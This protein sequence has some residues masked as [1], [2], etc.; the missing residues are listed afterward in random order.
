[1][2]RDVTTMEIRYGHWNDA[3]EAATEINRLCA[4]RGLRPARLL[5]SSFGP[6]NRMVAE[7]E[8]DSLAQIEE[9]QARF[10]S[11]A[12]IM[13]QVRI[14]A[15]VTVQGSVVEQLLQDAEHIA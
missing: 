11:D 2:F 13:K 5:I 14:L 3:I 7:V 1:M 15:E 12:D 9:E 8:Y 4:D 10:Y 6:A